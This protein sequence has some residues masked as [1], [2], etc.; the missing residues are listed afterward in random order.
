MT[1]CEGFANLPQICIKL[2]LYLLISFNFTQRRVN[3]QHPQRHLLHGTTK[4]YGFGAQT[5]V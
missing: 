4:I 3:T 2:R 5:G 1:A